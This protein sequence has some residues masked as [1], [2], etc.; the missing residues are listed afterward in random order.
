MAATWAHDVA[1]VT[2]WICATY[3]N[4][5]STPYENTEDA[6]WQ[7]IK[8]FITCAVI[9]S[10]L[11]MWAVAMRL[12]TR[13]SPPGD[14]LTASAITRLVLLI[15]FGSAKFVLDANMKNDQ[16]GEGIFQDAHYIVKGIF[17]QRFPYCHDNICTEFV[18]AMSR[19][20]A[21]AAWSTCIVMITYIVMYSP[22]WRAV[23]VCCLSVPLNMWLI[24]ENAH[25]KR[26]VQAMLHRACNDWLHPECNGRLE[27]VLYLD[28]ASIVIGTFA[29]CML[30]F[31]FPMLRKD[32][33]VR[34]FHKKD[35]KCLTPESSWS[36]SSKSR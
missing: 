17:L 12:L 22:K 27:Y 30:L 31:V 10:E 16:N 7:R 35:D 11:V 1:T 24:Y 2:K 18:Q 34:K 8:V 23:N 29:L 15:V 36:Q 14:T 25:A 5:E 3:F 19:R 28:R 6:D 21:D 9:L 33:T 26:V 4:D 13:A 20:F 32:G